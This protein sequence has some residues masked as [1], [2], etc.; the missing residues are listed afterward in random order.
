MTTLYNQWL[1]QIAAQEHIALGVCIIGLVYVLLVWH[2]AGARRW[3]IWLTAALFWASLVWLII[4]RPPSVPA[5]GVLKSPLWYDEAF[6][7]SVSRLPFGRMMQAIAG[8]VHPP[9]WYIVEWAIIRLLG[10][11]EAA[12]RLPALLFGILGVWLTFRVAL[13]LGYTR[14]TSLWSAVLLAAAPAWVYYAQ[15][16]RMYTL[17]SC[18]VLAAVLGLVTRR[19]W[20]MALGMV[21]ALY[22]HNLGA[23]Y[24]AVIAGLAAWRHASTCRGPD[25][26]SLVT[27]LALVGLAWIPWLAV[28]WRQV[29]DVADGFW[30][31]DYGLGGY[32]LAAYRVSLGMGIPAFLEI[33]GLLAVVG[34]ISLSLWGAWDDRHAIVPVVLLIAPGVVLAG[35][36]EVWRPVYLYRALLPSLPFLMILLTAALAGLGKK[37]RRPLLAVLIPLVVLCLLWQHKEGGSGVEVANI[38]SSRYQQQSDT[39]YHANLSSYILL[40]Y[41]LP[42]NDGYQHIAWPD[43]GDLSQALSLETQQ[44]MG[45]HRGEAAEALSQ[46]GSRL[47]IVWIENPM[48][49]AAERAALENALDL[50]ANVEQVANLDEGSL[51]TRRVYL[52]QARETTSQ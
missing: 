42:E 30:I 17:L 21:A 50:G 39:I 14:S 3:T 23:V 5:P 51:I 25:R 49:T 33:H 40:S 34:L 15:E 43:A 4:V 7:W 8:D 32:L 44:A 26:R 12:L 22:T 13:A 1:A 45:I 2:F 37:Y 11:S 9:L 18:A 47:W 38:I 35:V 48:T 19:R 31:P 10:G 24:V 20:L 29:G 41:Y 27:T 28:L 36:S 6:T 46:D 52:V 16:A